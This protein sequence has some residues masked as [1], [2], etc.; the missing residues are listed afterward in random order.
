MAASSI[1]VRT[2][3]GLPRK[4]ALQSCP[5]VGRMI[6][7]HWARLWRT[8][9]GGCFK[10]EGE[11]DRACRVR[12]DWGGEVDT[13]TGDWNL[14]RRKSSYASPV[15]SIP[16][17][18]SNSCHS[19]LLWCFFFLGLL[20]S[21]I[22]VLKLGES[23]HKHFNHCSFFFFSL[24]CLCN[25]WF[26]SKR[27][28]LASCALVQSSTPAC[29]FAL[30]PSSPSSIRSHHFR[31]QIALLSPTPVKTIVRAFGRK[32]ATLRLGPN[33]QEQRFVTPP[34]PSPELVSIYR[35]PHRRPPLRLSCQASQS[36]GCASN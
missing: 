15:T 26:R 3:I 27:L 29:I 14:C 36:T 4:L 33:S 8:P 34:T 25:C 22:P 6:M 2:T 19:E 24:I 23:I 10:S 5:A 1:G 32:T 7:R 13:R 16:S 28:L 35:T 20:F 30:S 17:S 18:T 21:L 31:D 12:A 11:C 9:A